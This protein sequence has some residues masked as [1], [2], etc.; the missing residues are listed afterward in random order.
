MAKIYKIQKDL[1]SE[2]FCPT[3]VLSAFKLPQAQK[4]MAWRK[5]ISKQN[6]FS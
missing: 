1:V 3:S 5:A 2:Y 6:S 4:K